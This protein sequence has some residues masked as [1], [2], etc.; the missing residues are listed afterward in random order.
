MLVTLPKNRV[1]I[2]SRGLIPGQVA[3]QDC[4]YPIKAAHYLQTLMYQSDA[5]PGKISS[6]PIFYFAPDGTINGT[7]RHLYTKWKR[8]SEPAPR[9][10]SKEVADPISD[11]LSAVQ[12][13]HGPDAASISPCSHRGV[14]GQ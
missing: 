5:R 12:S 8:T 9:S 4:R 2:E 11:R 6:T 10:F 7:G 14:P 13:N 1:E 3:G